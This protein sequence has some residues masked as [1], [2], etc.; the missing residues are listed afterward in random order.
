MLRIAM[1]LAEED[2]IN[3]IAP[4]HDAVLIEA[5]IA[6]TRA[7]QFLKHGVH[8]DIVAMLR[9]A[10]RVEEPSIVPSSGVKSLSGTPQGDAEQWDIALALSV[11][12]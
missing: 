10:I 2:E 12:Y 3:V 5:P 6:F 9:P 8:L 11:L 4:V 7:D 1:C